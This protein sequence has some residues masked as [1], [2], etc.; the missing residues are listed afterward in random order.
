MM[1]ILDLM[2]STLAEALETMVFVTVIPDSEEAIVPDRPIL[3]QMSFSG[4]LCGTV[5]ILGGWDLGEII[6]EN[7]G[8]VDD[9]DE[10]IVLDAWKEICN[11][12]C[13]LLMP[14]I[15]SSPADVFDVTVPY[16][17]VREAD[18]W[19]DFANHPESHILNAEGHA[20]AMKIHVHEQ[21]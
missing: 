17:C 5:Q 9:P 21:S 8:C 6:A 20:V 19:G 1:K 10:G 15:G 2:V 13:G 12:T 7:M 18:M 14:Q 4:P 16:A 3:T 11:V